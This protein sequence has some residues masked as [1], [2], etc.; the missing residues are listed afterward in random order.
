MFCHQKESGKHSCLLYQA[1]FERYSLL[2]EQP[3][4]GKQQRSEQQLDF[5]FFCFTSGYENDEAFLR[6]CLGRRK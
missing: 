2:K 5:L 6:L 3:R 1:R 4:K